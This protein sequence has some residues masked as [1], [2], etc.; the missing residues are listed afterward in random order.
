M[1]KMN[2]FGTSIVSQ[3][4]NTQFEAPVYEGYVSPDG[5]AIMDIALEGMREDYQMQA[6]LHIADAQLSL[7]AVTESTEA[8]EIALESVVGSTFSK[9]KDGLKKLWSKVKA[10]FKSVRESITMM[11]SK[12][13]AFITKYKKTIQ[14]KPARGFEYTGYA[15]SVDAGNTKA[16]AAINAITDAVETV[17]GRLDKD[18]ELFTAHAQSEGMRS[19][20]KDSYDSSD[21][22]E[23]IVT[24]LASRV[25]TGSNGELSDIKEAIFKAYR[26]GASN[27]DTEE[28]KEF[29]KVTRST[30]IDLVEKSDKSIKVISDAEKAVDKTF[31]NALKLIGKA[32][33]AVGKLGNSSFEGGKGSDNSSNAVAGRRA[34][35]ATFASKIGFAARYGQTLNS[36]I[37]STAVESIKASAAEAERVLKRFVSYGGTKENT[38]ENPEDFEGSQSV[39][40]SFMGITGI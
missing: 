30:L 25:G 39:I 23:E 12:G 6:A 28:L 35:A 33:T 7:T 19:G 1:K 14:E 15:W 2:Y 5:S 26:S 34:K 37:A 20:A 36:A 18:V 31:S 22:Q 8:A 4:D 40:E 38:E 21:V 27:G 11:F 3:P 9:I 17:S 10:W 32:E 29:S 24:A 16:T 13:K